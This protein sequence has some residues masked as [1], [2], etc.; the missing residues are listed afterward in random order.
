M[1]E[2]ACNPNR[3]SLA[4]GRRRSWSEG[5]GAGMTSDRERKLEQQ[6]EPAAALKRGKLELVLAG[7]NRHWRKTWDVGRGRSP[8]LPK[9]VNIGLLEE[10]AKSSGRISTAQVRALSAAE[11]QKKG[12][13]KPEGSYSF[14]HC[15]F[16]QIATKSI[17]LSDRKS[18]KKGK[19]TKE[20]S[21]VCRHRGGGCRDKCKRASLRL[22]YRVNV[23]Q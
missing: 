10:R 7:E 1:I 11:A 23:C 2:D 21:T 14:G 9:K 5:R 6:V 16:Y 15:Y 17:N 22:V 8:N 18:S 20:E 4:V 12:R 13:P 3:L 19:S